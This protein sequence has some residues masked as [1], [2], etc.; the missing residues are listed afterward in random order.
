MKKKL[1][2]LALGGLLFSVAT[3]VNAESTTTIDNDNLSNSQSVT[4]GNVETPVFNVNV[5]WGDMSFDWTY[6]NTTKEYG[7]TPTKVCTSTGVPTEENFTAGGKEYYSDE[8]CST[9]ITEYNASSSYYELEKRSY[10]RIGIEDMSERVEIV[11]SIKWVA[12]EDYSYVDAKIVA[13][14][15]YCTSIPN[16]EAFELVKSFSLYSDSTCATKTTA[17]T[18]ES[19]K[20]YTYA[21]RDQIITTEEIPDSARISGAGSSPTYDGVEYINFAY[22]RNFYMLDFNLVNKTTPATT[23]TKNAVIGTVTISIKEKE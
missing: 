9:K 12:S 15:I 23:P 22:L 6:N 16:A 21:R 19:G 7:W 1:L 10:V 17:T 4:V 3:N 8:S 14:E 11:P 2:G 5:Y 13:D 18:F 20:F